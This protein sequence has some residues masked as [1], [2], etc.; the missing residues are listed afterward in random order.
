MSTGLYEQYEQEHRLGTL[1]PGKGERGDASFHSPQN[2]A[3]PQKTL[4]TEATAA[5]VLRKGFRQARKSLETASA[6]LNP[7]LRGTC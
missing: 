6:H 3:R 5:S 4:D 2:A 1:G 7:M